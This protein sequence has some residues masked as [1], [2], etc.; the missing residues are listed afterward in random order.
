MTIPAGYG[1]VTFGYTGGPV[2]TGAVNT[3][4]FRNLAD[5]T[6]AEAAGA[7][8]ESW[9]QAIVPLLVETI[10]FSSVLVKLGPDEDGPSAMISVDEDG[11]V[12]DGAAS[13][14]VSYLIHKNTNLGGRRGR[15]RMFIPGVAETLVDGA[16]VVDGPA[17]SSFDS[18]FETLVTAWGVE[19]LP[20][21][22]LH[23]GLLSPTI[24]SSLT[25]DA[26]VATQRRRLRR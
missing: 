12:D 21:Y 3:L 6:P 4:G 2:P 26:R 24:I 7:F 5:A 22:L 25:C 8:G 16:G 23:D 14:N 15:G 13:P 11:G 20:P 18:A 10:T 1:Q 19:N 17:V 9:G